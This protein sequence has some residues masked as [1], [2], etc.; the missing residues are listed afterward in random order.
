[1]ACLAVLLNAFGSTGATGPMVF[2]NWFSQ[3]LVNP[4]IRRWQR[5]NP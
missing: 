2:E 1:M 3:R 5:F 4:R